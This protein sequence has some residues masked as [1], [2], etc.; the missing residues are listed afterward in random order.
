MIAHLV[1]RC[2]RREGCV[3]ERRYLLYVHASKRS[4]PYPC[5]LWKSSSFTAIISQ[6]IMCIMVSGI[7]QKNKI[8][9]EPQATLVATKRPSEKKLYR[10]PYLSGA[11]SSSSEL[12]LV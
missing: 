4:R 8:I 10:S 12:R 1:R 7:R 5:C 9:D 6:P 2:N 11:C 3:V